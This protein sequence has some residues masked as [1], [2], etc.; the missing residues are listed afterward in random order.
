MR[1]VLKKII[2][3]FLVLCIF[4]SSVL[5]CYVNTYA[6]VWHDVG[7]GYGLGKIFETWEDPNKSVL[8]KII[9]TFHYG[10]Y[11]M[12]PSSDWLHRPTPLQAAQEE[13]DKKVAEDTGKDQSEITEDD[14][15]QWF[16]QNVSI[17]NNRMITTNN[18]NTVIKNYSNYIISQSGYRYLY[19]YDL[20]DHY[21][22]YSDGNYYNAL[23]RFVV[24]NQNDNYCILDWVGNIRLL[25]K[26]Y[27][28]FVGVSYS[29]LYSDLTA[30]Q[31]FYL[32]DYD[33][34]Q[35]IPTDRFGTGYVYDSDLKEFVEGSA[36]PSWLRGSP[37][38]D[39]SILR[40]A[41]WPQFYWVNVNKKEVIKCY[42]TLAD[43][44]ADTQGR[45]PYYITNTWND[46]IN[47]TTNY[48]IDNSNYNPVTYNE[49]INHNE[50]IYNQTGDYPTID[51]IIRW[52]EERR[53][54]DPT[55]TP[56]PTP[57]PDPDNPLIDPDDPTPTPTHNP[58]DPNDFDP[59]HYP[60]VS[61]NGTDDDTDGWSFWDFLKG[62]IKALKAIAE[63]IAGI[64]SGIISWFTIDTE[65]I[66]DHVTG[67]MNG[68]IPLPDS[69]GGVSS[70]SISDLLIPAERI[71]S[72]GAAFEGFSGSYYPKLTIKTP[73]IIKQYYPEEEIILLD[74]ADWAMYFQIV[75]TL[76]EFSFWFAEIYYLISRIR[77]TIS[78]V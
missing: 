15:K 33:S 45:S 48:T 60:T 30:C 77:P 44:K 22:L 53:N 73:A 52:I 62:I 56:T 20:L 35:Y 2:S 34:W 74:F 13:L 66:S 68:T 29:G 65:E 63:G 38:R 41:N 46:F 50:T 54:P 5:F 36:V 49:I 17:V 57:T 32:Y 10:F 6:D 12:V 21:Q 51:E 75:R 31:D 24:L 58:D 78:I 7:Q 27:A 76:L 43:L 64:V 70:N 69:S 23:R 18:F 47:S 61:G 8:D 59:W 3:F 28:D 26:D 9:D 55:P 25:P 1:N 14:R 16:N 42:N 4:I 71:K 11:G 39:N 37:L 72:I 19:T 67:V 40:V